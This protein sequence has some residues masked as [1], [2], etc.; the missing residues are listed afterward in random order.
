MFEEE[1]A[2]HPLAQSQLLSY[3]M[4]ELEPDELQRLEAQIKESPTLQAELEEIRAH[5]SLH[6]EVRKVAPRRGSFDRL[7][8]RMGQEGALAGAVPGVHRMLRRSFLIAALAGILFI[9]LM[10]WYSDA[11]RVAPL[12][13]TEEVIGQIIYYEPAPDMI[14][15]HGREIDH[16][17]ALVGASKNTG[18]YDASIW[19]PT[20]V[21]RSYSIIE[22]APQTELKFVSSREIQLNKGF[23]RQ[24]SI[25]PGAL[26]ESAFVVKTPH[27]RVEVSGAKLAIRVNEAETQVTVSEGS[28]R[29]IGGDLP[30]IVHAGHFSV[31]VRDSEA[32][33][34]SP[35]LQMTLLQYHDPNTS[36]PI[37]EVNLRNVGF[38]PTRIQKAYSRDPVYVLQV[39]RARDY[40]DSGSTGERFET[41][42]IGLVDSPLNHIGEMWLKPKED[43]RFRI[44]ISPNVYGR[45]AAEYWIVVV[46]KGGIYGPPGAAR[47]DVSSKP[48]KLDLKKK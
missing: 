21:S 29:V 47:I 31:I 2:T 5:L 7:M 32:T 37:I 40:G 22:C 10:A 4:G 24:L 25:A 43:Y 8:R 39:S 12:P 41:P 34:P 1:R 13:H 16:G 30:Q 17:E 23:F 48:E 11:A 33:P 27:G 19:L 46:Y 14:S 15:T 36:V 35:V 3:V 6:Q 28:A 9:A 42:D 44:D 20:G 18:S 38:V 26:G 45:P